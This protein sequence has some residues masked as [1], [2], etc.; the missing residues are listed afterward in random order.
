M[1]QVTQCRQE[2]KIINDLQ[3]DIKDSQNY[4][5]TIKVQ[6]SR[7]VQLPNGKHTTTCMFCHA[8]CHKICYFENDEEK[9]YCS[10]MN[11]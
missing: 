10:G 8:T 11:K 1:N 3:K 2:Y 5:I 4:T 7:Q 9:K 6:Q